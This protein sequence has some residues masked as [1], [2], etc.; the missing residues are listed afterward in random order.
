MWL[1]VP[2]V[3]FRNQSLSE[4]GYIWF[5]GSAF[6]AG[7]EAFRFDAYNLV[8]HASSTWLSWTR[9]RQG[10]R[11]LSLEQNLGKWYHKRYESLTFLPDTYFAES[12][13][14][15]KASSVYMCLCNRTFS[16]TYYLG[17][18][19]MTWNLE[20]KWILIDNREILLKVLYIDYKT[21]C[22]ALD[23]ENCVLRWNPFWAQTMGDF[24]P[25][26]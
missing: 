6:F 4:C 10:Y 20:S 11:P 15:W 12:P 23:M 24:S 21:S 1:P 26:F 5:S 19:P 25:I 18:R 2:S 9:H 14:A 22:A 3:S 13:L 7:L 8:R 16:T 17:W